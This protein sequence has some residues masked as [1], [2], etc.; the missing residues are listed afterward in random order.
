MLRR[1]LALLMAV[2]AACAAGGAHAQAYP[3]KPIRFI[4]PWA[5]GGST[6]VLARIIAQ[7]LQESWSQPV[8]VEIFPDQKDFG[9]RTFGMPDNPGFLGVCFGH[10]ITANS[11]ASAAGLAALFPERT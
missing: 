5:P 7:K 4:V 8:L 10:V 6:D 1:S 9:V 2:L 3:S 11:P